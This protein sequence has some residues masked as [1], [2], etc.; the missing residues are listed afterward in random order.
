MSALAIDLGSSLLIPVSSASPARP[1]KV[2]QSMEA[3]SAASDEQLAE[4]A[5][6]GQMDAF[7]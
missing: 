2:V 4:A 6:Q 3:F 7:E 1:S 5:R